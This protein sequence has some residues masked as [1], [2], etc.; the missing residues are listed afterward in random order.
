LVGLTPRQCAYA[1][2]SRLPADRDQRRKK[3]R[4]ALDWEFGG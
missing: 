4:P 1:G 3:S 2:G